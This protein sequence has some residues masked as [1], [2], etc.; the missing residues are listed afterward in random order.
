MTPD[1]FAPLV[2]VLLRQVPV[3]LIYAVGAVAAGFL[4]GRQR[5][6]ALLC[7]IGCAL[8][9]VTILVLSGAEAWVVAAHAR[10]GW[11]AMRY[12]QAMALV[13]LAGAVLRPLGLALV[14]VAVFV[15]RK[16]PG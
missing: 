15:G 10:E 8:S 3:L 6:P 7:L 2:S 14:V 9:I 13:G 5:A 11:T 4:L 16:Q 1:A 12:G